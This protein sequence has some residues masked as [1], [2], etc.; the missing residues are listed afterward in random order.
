MAPSLPPRWLK[1][2]LWAGIAFFVVIFAL[3]MRGRRN[4]KYNNASEAVRVKAKDRMR[5]LD[6]PAQERVNAKSGDQA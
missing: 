4:V 1:T 6:I 3:T 5:L 2:T